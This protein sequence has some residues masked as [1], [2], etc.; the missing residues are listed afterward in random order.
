M[1]ECQ[2]EHYINGFDSFA[3]NKVREHRGKM[4]GSKQGELVFAAGAFSVKTGTQNFNL[5]L[6]SMNYGG[7]VLA[8]GAKPEVLAGDTVHWLVLVQNRVATH[9][10]GTLRGLPRQFDGIVTR[11]TASLVAGIYLRSDQ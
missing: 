10:L 2:S 11:N 6:T 8:V 3:I 7:P 4:D 5:I 1:S 9:I